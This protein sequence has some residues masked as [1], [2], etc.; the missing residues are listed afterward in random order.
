MASA[1]IHRAKSDKTATV[2]VLDEPIPEE[3]KL[4]DVDEEIVKR[5]KDIKARDDTSNAD[6]AG[7]SDLGIAQRLAALKG[8]AHKESK[9]D[10][11]LRNLDNRTDQQ[12]TDDLV[13]QFMAETEIDREAN[14]GENDEEEDPIK[15]IERRLAALKGTTGK[16]SA[17]SNI[18]NVESEDEET[19]TNKLAAKVGHRPFAETSISNSDAISS[20]WRKQPCQ[21]RN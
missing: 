17:N 4:P 9:N 13:K 15:S 18:E 3:E 12:K 10:D 21:I 6:E 5:L 19:A 11:I 16:D 20:T 1:N 7:T 8:V 14:F 2:S